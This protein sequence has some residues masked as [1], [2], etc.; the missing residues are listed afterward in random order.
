MGTLTYV[1]GLPT[2]IE[3]LNSIGMSTFEMFLNDFSQVSF[4]AACET[5]NHLLEVDKFN[6]SSW[7]SYLQKTYGINKRHAG[8]IIASSEGRVKAAIEHRKLHIQTLKKKLKFTKA[9]LKTTNKKLKSCAK[10]YS[11]D[12]WSKSKI[13]CLLPLSCSLKSR[14]TN[15]ANLEFQVHNKNRQAY[16]LELLLTHLPNK[17]LKIKIPK[18]D[19]FV[20]GSKSETLGNQVCQWDGEYIK[21][22]VPYCLESKYGRNVSSKLG[23]FN[24]NI[25][26]IPEGGARTGALL[27]RGW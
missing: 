16:R 27:D 13:S 15:K 2:P 12:N 22:R 19:V 11:K 4:K 7:N 17:P 20:V 10:F 6:K 21:F 5:V 25:N 26:R 23:N 9:W 1:K 24:R 8:G 18:N 3:E 14:N